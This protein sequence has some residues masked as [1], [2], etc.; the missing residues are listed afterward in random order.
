MIER[1]DPY[2]NTTSLDGDIDNVLEEELTWNT[3]LTYLKISDYLPT[4]G[5]QTI[6]D[7][8]NTAEYFPECEKQ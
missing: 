6:S 3:G 1:F 4:T 8:N 2:G 7:E 5:F